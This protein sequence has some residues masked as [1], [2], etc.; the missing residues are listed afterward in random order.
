[1]RRVNHAGSDWNEALHRDEL[2]FWRAALKEPEKNWLASEFNERTQPDLELQPFIRELIQAP[3]G[4]RVRILDVGAGPLTRVGRK[5]DGRVLEIVAVDPLAKEFDD[6]LSECGIVPPVRTV[7]GLAENLV[8]QFPVNSFDF[9]YASNCLDHSRDPVA[10]IRQMLEV[11]KPG[12]HAYLWHFANVGLQECYAG[13]HQWN[14]DVAG[15][16]FLISDGRS[17]F[18]LASRV[19]D[20]AT[21]SCGVEQAFNNRVVVARLRKH[22]A[23]SPARPGPA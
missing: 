18:A 15:D 20:L 19:A 23:V 5:W 17:R 16:E 13:L 21:V 8:G 6:L 10:A 4:S 1:L 22:D 11:I 3:A 2:A 12:C 14:F 9:A 7:F